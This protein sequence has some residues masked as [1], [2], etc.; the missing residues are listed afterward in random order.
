MEFPIKT[1]PA[2]VRCSD[3]TCAAYTNKAES[4][5]FHY[6]PRLFLFGTAWFLLG[7]LVYL[8]ARPRTTSSFFPEAASIAAFLP[9]WLRSLLGPVP[10]FVHVIAFSM[11]SAALVGRTYKKQLALCAGWAGIEI[12]FEVAQHPLIRNWLLR[13]DSLSSMPF[14]SKYLAG[15][16]DYADILAAIVGASLTAL[17]LGSTRSKSR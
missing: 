5:E 13:T 4:A 12:V 17:F 16:F 9:H 7:V 14:I 11:M 8:A 1:E 2:I 6:K 3:G 15:T 10:T